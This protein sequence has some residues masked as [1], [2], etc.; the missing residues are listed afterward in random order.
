MS[1]VPAPQNITV[2]AHPSKWASILLAILQ[3]AAA[4]NQIIATFLPAPVEAG[5][6]VA[7]TLGP[8][9]VGTIQAATN[10]GDTAS[11]ASGTSVPVA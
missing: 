11:T 1:T 4:A 5:I 10:A 7:T 6:V 8:V 2:T 3:A 9:V